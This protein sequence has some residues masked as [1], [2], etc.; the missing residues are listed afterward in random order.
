LR[1]REFGS[2]FRELMKPK[3]CLAFLKEQLGD[4]MIIILIFAA[5]LSLVLNFATSSVEEYAT[6]WIDGTAILIAVIVVTGVG[7][8]VDWR[9]E[10]EFVN[11]AND[12]N[13]E[14]V[15]DVVRN[16]KTITDLHHNYVCV[17]DI[18][19]LKYGKEIPVDGIFLAGSDL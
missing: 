8:M 19:E 9:K 18:L 2:N 6:A 1:D 16:G 11:R 14:N 15:I 10:I 13:K 4:I 5:V 3:P 12:E 7:S 17:G